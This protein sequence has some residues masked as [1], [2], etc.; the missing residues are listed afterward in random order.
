MS[1]II[2]NELIDIFSFIKGY[3]LTFDVTSEWFQDLWYPLSKNQPSLGG[4]LIKVE[5]RPIIITSNLLEW[6][7]YKRKKTMMLA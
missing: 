2:S 7:G 6:L 5:N 4:G 1:T 3:N